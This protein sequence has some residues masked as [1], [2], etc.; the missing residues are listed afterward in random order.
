MLSRHRQPSRASNAIYASLAMAV[1]PCCIEE[2]VKDGVV[3]LIV[4]VVHD[5]VHVF[6]LMTIMPVVS[7]RKYQTLITAVLMT[8]EELGPKTAEAAPAPQPQWLPQVINK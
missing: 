6:Q 7:T 4:S 8:R 5:P 3:E 2:Q 1:A